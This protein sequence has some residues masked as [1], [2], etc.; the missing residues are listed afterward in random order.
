MSTIVQSLWITA[1]GMSLVF[2]GIIVLWGLM[3]VL[4]YVF[5]EKKPIYKEKETI[6]DTDELEQKRLA[7]AIAVACMIGMYNTSISY[8][9]HKERESISAWQAVHRSHQIH[10]NTSHHSIKRSG[11][12][13]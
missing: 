6:A 11:K 10:R 4:V 9:S 7:A 12:Q 8:S 3:Q 5:T 2:I 13:P 1:I